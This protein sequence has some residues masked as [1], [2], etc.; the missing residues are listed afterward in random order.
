MKPRHVADASR[1]GPYRWYALALLTSA[2]ICHYI[3]RNVI[4]VAV[5][6][7]RREFNLS[8][9]QVGML[10]GLAYAVAFAL[11]ALPMGYLV[12][13]INRRNLLAAIMVCWSALTATSGFAQSHAQLLLARM[14]VGASEAGGHPTA[15]S[16]IADY[17]GPRQRSTAL[18]V[19]YLSAGLGSATIFIVGGYV[20]QTYGWRHAF[21]LAGIPGL[22]VALLVLLT[23]REPPR[24]QTEIQAQSSEPAASLREALTYVLARPAILHLIAGIMLASAMTSA[25]ALWT[26]SFFVRVHGMKISDIGVWIALGLGLVGTIVPLISAT[27][28]DRVAAPRSGPRPERLAFVS[29]GTAACVVIIATA[30]ALTRDTPIALALMCA[31]AGL[32][33]AHNGPANGLLISLFRPRMRGVVAATAQILTALTGVGVGPYL[34]GV[35]SDLY[36]GSDSLRWAIVTG[37]VVNL[38]AAIHFLLAG[39]AVRR[40]RTKELTRSLGRAF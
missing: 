12:D 23:L 5:E 34:V 36:G 22:A 1:A 32:M 38:W 9:S 6:P 16:L 4:S 7:M 37:M 17:F 24:G 26:M 30:M 8:D 11:A 27:L 33:L 20:V 19:W 28:A 18:G 29:A 2:Q 3:D 31:W 39:L 14:G 25:F 15:V 13:R 10:G 35:L 40:D 21:Y